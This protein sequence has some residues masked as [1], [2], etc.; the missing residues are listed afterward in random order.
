LRTAQALAAKLGL[1]LTLLNTLVGMFAD[2][3]ECFGVGLD[4]SAILQEV[5]RRSEKAS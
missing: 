3:I 1:D 5:E 2:M 4:V